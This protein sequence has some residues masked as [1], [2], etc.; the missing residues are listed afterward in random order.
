MKYVKKDKGL[1]FGGISPC[2]HTAWTRPPVSLNGARLHGWGHIPHHTSH[3]TL[4]FFPTRGSPLSV[5]AFYLTSPLVKCMYG[6]YRQKSMPLIGLKNWFLRL[7]FY[8]RSLIT[9]AFTRSMLW[10][11]FLGR[12]HLLWFITPVGWKFYSG[13][14][15]CEI[16]DIFF[17]V[18]SNCWA[19]RPRAWWS[20][21]QVGLNG[22]ANVKRK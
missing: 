16:P 14:P 5:S 12:N 22:M 11:G 6:T 1:C 21:L 3:P 4:S 20:E 8:R 10:K 13:L 19:K 2:K 7:C 9:T 17:K 15:V 18:H